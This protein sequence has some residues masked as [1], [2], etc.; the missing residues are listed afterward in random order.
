MERAHLNRRLGGFQSRSG[1]FV[2]E[3]TSSL[4]PIITL[5]TLPLFPFVEDTYEKH[6]RIRNSYNYKTEIYSI[7]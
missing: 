3:L 4:C 1:H 7:N 2:E 5:N 6:V